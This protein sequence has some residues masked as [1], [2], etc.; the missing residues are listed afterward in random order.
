MKNNAVFRAAAVF[1]SDMVLQRSKPVPVW[2]TGLPGI[3]VRCTLA[4][5]TA[6]ARADGQGRWQLELPAMP[7]GGPYTM[8]LSGGEETI[9]FERVYLGEVWLAGGQSNMDMKLQDSANGEEELARSRDERVHFYV[10]PQVSSEGEILEQA[11]AKTCWNVIGPETAAN[12]S[13]V[14]YY[15]A[16]RLAESLNGIH[17][18]VVQCSWGGTSA[19]CWMSRRQLDKTA[20]GR[21]CLEE[22]DQRCAALT[23]DQYQE[24]LADYR[25]R[26]ARWEQT[27]AR[28][29]QEEPQLS[30]AEKMAR[31]GDYPWPPPAGPD[32]FQC[33]GTLYRTMLRRVCPY[34]VRGV[35][36][37]Q[38]EEDD[39][40]AE[41]YA[42]LLGSLIAQWRSDWKDAELPFLLVQLPMY[43]P[44]GE[45]LHW[46]VLRSAQW[47]ISRLLRDVELLSLADCGEK[48]DIHPKDK[49]TPGRRLAALALDAVYGLE[50][51][52][53]SPR[54]RRVEYHPHGATIHFAQCGG[55]LRLDGEAG[56]AL[57]G[58]DGVFH[59][60][61]P[62]VEGEQ[63]LL[64][65]SEVEEPCQ[66]RY[67]W[68]NFGPAPLHSAAGM[69]AVPFWD[70]RGLLR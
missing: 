21:R 11:E 10:T 6:A 45:G 7:A 19:A 67:A 14:A 3:T 20:A 52:R 42:A 70:D 64:T 27:L 48:N 60:A 29:D 18:G 8:E 49:R 33:P 15:F 31:T 62:Q 35:A 59:P 43:G 40:H 25:A 46:P 41:D 56:F 4:G 12:V 26:I 66:A 30:R 9:R 47:S 63:V 34:G 51:G 65:C 1:G 38:A 53:R 69:A 54:A 37:Y 68:Y 58:A 23:P 57:A 5:Q 44:E 22:F 13:A 17:V 28:L 55:G 61:S 2:G 24:Q 50:E 39:P 32:S 16:R 36:Y